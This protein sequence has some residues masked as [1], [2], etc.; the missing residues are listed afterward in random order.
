MRSA[1][2]FSLVACAGFVVW[3]CTGSDPDTTPGS[4]ADGA[5][6]GDCR[7]GGSC[8]PGL[9]CT[10][11]YCLHPGENVPPDLDAGT[12]SSGAT[13]S[14]G[15]SGTTTS[16]GGSS[17][18]SGAF[19]DCVAPEK[20][21]TY[22]RCEGIQCTNTN[23]HCCYTD[24][25]TF[26]SP[27]AQIGCGSANDFY[28]GCD[29]PASCGGGYACCLGLNATTAAGTKCATRI[30]DAEHASCKAGTCTS[31]DLVVCDAR[32]DAGAQSCPTSKTCQT[33]EVKIGNTMAIVL[34]DVCL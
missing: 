10:D 26:C 3:A 31:G 11:G 22:P 29:G 13:S 33:V 2:L 4:P 5:Y 20:G 30:V 15:S 12:G 1:L 14:G 18:T 32:A 23:P 28:V 9:V 7:P 16:S 6:R 19:P 17:G 8:D 27:T 34:L 24:A 25:P 21:D